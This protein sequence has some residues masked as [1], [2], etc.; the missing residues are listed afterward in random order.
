MSI[1]NNF[2]DFIIEVCMGTAFDCEENE[3]KEGEI[4][5]VRTPIKRFTS[6]QQERL[7]KLKEHAEDVEFEEIQG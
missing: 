2:N 6:E 7:N 1:F 3:V 5:V 4:K